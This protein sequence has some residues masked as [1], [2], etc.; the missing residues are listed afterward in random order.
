MCGAGRA[1]A[2]TS[3]RHR[4]VAARRPRRG[5]CAG[6]RRWDGAGRR[7]ARKNRA[8]PVAATAVRG[9]MRPARLTRGW[10][11]GLLTATR[12]PASSP[13][14]ASISASRRSGATSDVPA[15]AS[16]TSACI[17]RATPAR[18][19]VCANRRASG[20]ATIIR[21]RHFWDRLGGETLALA[22][23]GGRWHQI[24]LQ[25]PLDGPKSRVRQPGQSV[26]CRIGARTFGT[27]GNDRWL[28]R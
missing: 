19:S 4:G 16:L 11:S 25:C 14:S 3:R 7:G 12:A 8:R 1:E 24:P 20:W 17:C 2:A 28:G 27:H 26:E 18:R 6:P 15:R 21:C 10:S 23:N 13:T 9:E 22:P 5:W